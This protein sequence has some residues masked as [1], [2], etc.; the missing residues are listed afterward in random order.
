LDSFYTK[1]KKIR[2]TRREQGLRR[3][4]RV[5]RSL[6][7]GRNF[8]RAVL[9]MG[10]AYSSMFLDR[11]FKLLLFLLSQQS[12]LCKYSEST[13][14][15]EFSGPSTALTPRVQYASA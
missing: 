13:V 9:T 11:I 1:R 12:F 2:G 14:P 4:F 10:N 6:R 7:G 3:R 15:A 5:F 8:I